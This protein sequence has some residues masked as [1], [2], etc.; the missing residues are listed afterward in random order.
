MIWNYN[1]K[2]LSNFI[3]LGIVQCINLLIPLLVIPYVILKIGADMFGV[4]SIAQ[5]V[6]IYSAA[7][8]DWGFN[9]SATRD[10]ALYQDDRA[11]IS[12]VFFTVL[13]S[14]LIITAVLFIL[15][16]GLALFFPIF[17]NVLTIYTMGFTYVLGQAL[18][19]NWF[20]QGVERMH[21][22]ALATLVSRL[23]FVVLIFHFIHEK[24]DG[25]YFIFFLGVGNILA[26]CLS[27]IAAISIYKLKFFFPS[28]SNIMFELK[29]GWKITL[30]NLSINTYLYC[31]II[32]LR[33]F[34]N[35]FIVGYYS[36]AERIY[37][38][39]R[40]VL[41]IF[42]QVIYPPVCQLINKGKESGKKFFRQV[43]FPFFILTIAGC[44]MLFIFSDQITHIFL[45]HNLALPVLLLKSLSF[46]PVIICLNI[47]AYQLLL[48]FN[49]KKSYF[50]LLILAS[51]IN[52]VSNILLVNI[53][54]AM[55]TVISI[56]ITEL[57]ITIG[58]NRQL[59]KNNLGGYVISGMI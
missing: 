49:R 20:F 15:F 54:G 27:I 37:F 50:S 43:Y 22:I 59:Y 8:A 56:I 4:I 42:S 18:F 12:R 26:A 17:K 5:V 33:I 7:I 31:G 36:I 47:P 30:S 58:L 39:A 45:K 25:I 21:F 23:L 19:V 55:G 24:S 16:I 32:I 11:K 1:R 46:V 13:A 28:C 53:W 48:A 9:I 40:Q 41:A 38:A 51:F 10:I 57:F 14:K 29:D 35:D 44:F 52:I 3:A 6:M 34:T 2:L